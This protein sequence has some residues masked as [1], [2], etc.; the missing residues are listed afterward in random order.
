MSAGVE[1][2]T[3]RP[4]TAGELAQSLRE[5]AEKRRAIQLS[6]AGSKRLMAGP[7]TRAKVS[8]STTALT[9][10]LAYEPNDLTIS[11]EAGMP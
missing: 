7:I 4:T 10:V 9:R 6:G 2:G 3:L 11:V 1:S 8:I 5:A